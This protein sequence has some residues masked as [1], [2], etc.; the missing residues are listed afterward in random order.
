MQ[1]KG[2]IPGSLWSYFN[3]LEKIISFFAK[4]VEN[5]CKNRVESAFFS[6]GFFPLFLGEDDGESEE[7]VFLRDG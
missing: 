5:Q 4:K 1:D 6:D 3:L 7:V 2:R